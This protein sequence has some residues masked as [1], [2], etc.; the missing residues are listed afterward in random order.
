MSTE[1]QTPTPQ[2]D[3]KAAFMAVY[4]TLPEKVDLPYSMTPEGERMAKFKKICPQEFLK[5]IDREKLPKPEAFDSV[6]NWTGAFP[7]P[8]AVGPTNTAKTRATWSVL[9]R[10]YVREN[11]PFAWFPVRR[12]ITELEKFESLNA[13]DEFFRAYSFYRV[14]MVD[15]V[16]KI[17]WQF[18]SHGALLF[19]F[20]DWVYRSR[21][22][23]ITTTNKDRK[24]WAGKM[25]DAF[26]RR[27]FDDAHFEVKF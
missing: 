18:E 19:A 5:K 25:G 11:K 1:E 13:A 23:C 17:N 2:P 10:L 3:W 22:P 14:L 15:D 7:G 27:L 6:F 24:W 8:C 12:M 4:D 26:T 21:I 20:Y 9:G 16:D